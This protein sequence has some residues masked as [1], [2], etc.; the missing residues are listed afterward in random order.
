LR[1]RYQL[2]G[3]PTVLI[4]SGDGNEVDRICGY[5][6]DRELFMKTLGEYLSGTNTLKSL[7]SQVESDTMNIQYNYQMAKKYVARWEGEKSVPYFQRILDYDPDDKYGYHE[8]TNCYRAIYEIQFNKNP[9]PLEK[10]I[11]VTKQPEFMRMSY[12]N[13]VR[14]YKN[15]KKMKELY[16]VFDFG[17]E[18]FD[19][20]AAILND[21]AWSI[22]ENKVSDKYEQGIKMAR[23]AVKLQPE[24][25]HIWDTL[26][27]LLFANGQKDEALKYMKKA[28][29]LKPDSEYYRE[30]LV[31]MEGEHR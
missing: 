22:Y 5:D 27:W 8:E 31:K 2:R 30:N 1:E 20:D 16:A 28:L 3:Y 10:F 13:L 11:K 4:L 25:S 6:G 24:G 9:D 21:Y 14:F 23:K 12:N 26:S 7:L 19:N 29:E 15:Q 18:N 17:V